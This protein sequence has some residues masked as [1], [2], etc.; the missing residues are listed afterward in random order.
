V[1]FLR[2]T[3]PAAQAFLSGLIAEIPEY[4][5]SAMD[6]LELLLRE[7][8][9]SSTS[10]LSVLKSLPSEPASTPVERQR[11]LAKF[12]EPLL[13]LCESSDLAQAAA[14]ALEKLESQLAQRSSVPDKQV[15][16]SL[17]TAEAVLENKG[18]LVLQV[19]CP[20]DGCSLYGLRI[21]AD[22]TRGERRE[23]S[24]KERYLLKALQ[25]PAPI[26]VL[27]PGERREV[28]LV[29]ERFDED[30]AEASRVELSYTVP[31]P[32][33]NQQGVR[34]RQS[35]FAVHLQRPLISAPPWPPH[36]YVLG[37]PVTDKD[38]IY[39]R[40][41][42][43]ERI[44][45]V[46][47][48][49]GQ[50][51]AV[52]VLGDRKI[53]K[54]TLLIA[55]ENHKQIQRRYRSLRIDFQDL[56]T[57]G[58]AA[59]FFREQLI[60]PL[61]KHIESQFGL[62]LPIE[63]SAVGAS[64]EQE[65]KLFVA[66]CDKLLA[67]RS[68]RVLL[69]L[70]ELERLFEVIAQRSGTRPGELSIEAIATL[71]S[72]LQ[73]AQNISLVMA[74]VTDIL[75]RRT[76]KKE[77][78]LFRF[79]VEV[80][81]KPLSEEA[82]RRLI[83]NP[84]QALY[85]FTTNAVERIIVETNRQPYLIKHVCLKLYESMRA[86]RASV[87]TEADVLGVMEEEIVPHTGHFWHLTEPVKDPKYFVLIKGLAALQVGRSY[88]SVADLRRQ[89]RRSGVD[90]SEVQLTERLQEIENYT[91]TIIDRQVGG[92]GHY[93]LTVGLFARHLRFLQEDRFRF[94]LG[95]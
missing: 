68:H 53:G 89:L 11:L 3:P 50:D 44:C 61:R 59:M 2:T 9:P 14:D 26:P 37:K 95:T 36:R 92:R 73:S 76:A 16:T 58:T 74:G 72:A 81:L 19:S 86:R 47:I 64:P 85:R 8:L 46:L 17:L 63:E 31:S 69:I 80:E 77:D 83:T 28:P 90:L 41:D 84:V 82:A 38:D 43:L 55:L 94:V 32:E 91:Q 79:A 51:N 7:L 54:T 75:R 13:D 49:Q 34:S 35:S 27:R 24:G 66:S 57:D 71:R 40:E 56:K 78:R 62:A 93:R 30:M 48:G 25:Q 65:F 20:E 33:G 21:K 70:D 42:D 4:L 22:L 5:S 6:V 88:V 12:R 67:G 18:R 29:F 23:G 39:G 52:L 1:S 60:A 15:V 10:L 87:V 45:N